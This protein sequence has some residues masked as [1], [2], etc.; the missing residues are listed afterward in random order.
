MLLLVFIAVF[1][2][3]SAK[4]TLDE[5]RNYYQL[6]ATQKVAAEKLDQ[7]TM[8]ID[9]NSDPVLIGYKG[10]NEMLQAKYSWNPIA[11]WNRFNKGR[12]L[13]QLAIKRD[14]TNLETR[15]L[16]YSIQSNIPSFLDY[17]AQMATDKHYLILNTPHI[18]D[19]KLKEIIVNY[20]VSTHTLTNT[21]LNNIKN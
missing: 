18:N 15:F 1:L 10:A 19:K 7:L 4:L 3:Q 21:E 9:T 2:H 11:K 5:L 17:H 16:R 8:M 6:A 14:N 20:F 12:T 13:L